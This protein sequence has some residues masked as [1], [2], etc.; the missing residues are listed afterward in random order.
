MDIYDAQPAELWPAV[1][2]NIPFTTENQTQ[3]ASTPK[4]SQ[5]TD[6]WLISAFSEMISADPSCTI[7]TEAYGLRLT[8]T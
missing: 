1:L 7:K 8:A 6:F 3:R 4:Y 5:L 2:A